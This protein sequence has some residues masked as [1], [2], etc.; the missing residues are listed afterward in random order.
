MPQRKTTAKKPQL[1][2][3]QQ[4]DLV[5][6]QI[7]L[8]S[9]QDCTL[10]SN[11]T[12]W[13]HAWFLDQVRQ[14]DPSVSA[15]LH[16]NQDEKAFTLSAFLSDSQ[17]NDGQQSTGGDRT[18]TFPATSTY[19]CHITALCAPIAVALR[20]WLTHPPGIIKFRDGTFQILDWQIA[21]PAT[22]YENLWE[23][24]KPSDLSLTFL[25]PTGFR[26]NGNHMPLPI[27][28]NLFHSYLR[29]WNTFA[30]LEF[31]QDSFLQWVNECVIL[32]RHDIRSRKAQPGKQGSVTGFIGTIQLGLTSKAKAEPEYVQLV[33]TLINA[34][35]YFGTGHKITFGLGQTRLGWQP[36]TTAVAVTASPPPIANNRSTPP[37]AEPQPTSPPPRANVSQ[38]RKTLLKARVEEL[39]PIFLAI[40]KRQGGDRAKHTA[41]LWANI[42]ARQESG[43]SLKSIAADLKLPYETVKKYAQ[44]ARKQMESVSHAL[45]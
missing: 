43:D 15:Y 4:T 34:A 29:R 28:E 2:W 37:L 32:Q 11:Y 30:H 38:L 22:T 33:H 10:P 5:G 44:L 21:T 6:L 41:Q 1:T 19:H 39:E 14:V 26:K 35:P 9:T 31:D 8:Q 25:S 17:I 12:Y 27:P 40:R 24:T 42:I 23:D 13:L 3:P 18:V 36:L 7:T 16:D 45:G 20:K